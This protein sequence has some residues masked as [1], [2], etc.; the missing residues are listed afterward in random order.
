MGLKTSLF[1]MFAFIVLGTFAFF[2]PLHTKQKEEDLKERESHV[3]W[4]KG[5][6]LEQLKVKSAK[7]E[8]ELICA[9]AAGCPF[10]GTGD[11]KIISPV[12]DRADPASVGAL[13]GAVMN[14]LQT[15]K[16]PLENGVDP[17][18]FGF[19]KPSAELE[20]RLKGEANAYSLKIGSA[21][22]VGPNAYVE[23]SASPN[24][25]FMVA[26]YFSAATQK[27]LFHWRNKRLFPEISGDLVN[28]LKWS[29][30]K[31]QKF[32]VIK[33]GQEWKLEEP[34]QAPAN[35]ALLEGLVTSLVY[36]D[37]KG[38]YSENKNSP[39]AKQALAALPEWQLSFQT[40]TGEWQS[41]T[42]YNNPKAAKGA[43]EYV[44][45]G[46]NDPRL[47][48]V[49][50][51]VIERFNK[52]SIE[53]RERRLIPEGELAGATEIV[54]RFPREQKEITLKLE[55]ENWVYAS[56]EK[57]AE[58]LSRD[59]VDSFFR[60]LS[61]V[62]ATSFLNAKISSDPAVAF[63][64]KQAPDLEVEFKQGGKPVRKMH[65]LVHERKEVLTESSVKDELAAL[66][67]PFLK[68][69]P[70][71]FSD[72]YESSNRRVVTT[73]AKEEEHGEHSHAEH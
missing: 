67:G 40:K 59:R 22:A 50:G 26:N 25:V 28:R 29:G 39:E 66:S 63:F 64:E 37:M 10:D 73:P 5:K 24:T 2:D 55:K 41:L 70:V 42:L 72:L 19:E 51:L 47:L 3:F 21:K 23:T 13:A 62:E 16:I 7:S 11:W 71:R 46:A 61:G 30:N 14:L 43:K 56:G 18:E 44:A 8:V 34:V 15:E 60:I 49:D 32:L 45:V 17:K 36:L 31:G 58:A 20:F 38:V 48:L 69:L 12:K 33:I 27:D 6:S 65:F 52:P 54:M 57:P 68:V 53:Y 4:L 1:L 35:F 9:K